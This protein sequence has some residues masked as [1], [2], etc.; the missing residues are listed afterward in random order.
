[1]KVSVRDI[2]FI[3]VVVIG[4]GSLVGGLLR[5]ARRVAASPT[6][7]PAD[8]ALAAAEL[9]PIVARVDEAFRAEREEQGLDRP[10]RR[11]ELTV[12]RRL[13]LSLC[14]TVPSLEEIRRFES[15]P[16]GRRRRLARRLL[17]DRRCTDYLAERFARA[18][19]G[20]EDGP[21]IRLPA[22]AFH[23]LA[24]RRAP[25][26]PPLRRARPR[27]DRRP[28]AMDRPSGDELRLRDV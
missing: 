25:R 4:A 13:S 19:V 26:E 10:R 1:M 8:G 15:R 2:A 21:F 6:P 5:P 14:G 28:R 11:A 23:R 9:K 3:A 16:A 7:T 17:H 22:A 27:N 12:M 20:T 24:Q 18:F